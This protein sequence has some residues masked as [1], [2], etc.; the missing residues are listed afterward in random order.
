VQ[1][2]CTALSNTSNNVQQDW[3][4]SW[5]GH[6]LYCTRCCIARC[7]V[8]QQVGALLVLLSAPSSCCITFCCVLQ[9][10]DKLIDPS[11]VS[12]CYRITKQIGMLATGLPGER[13]MRAWPAG[14]LGRS[15]RSEWAA[16]VLRC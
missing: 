8:E 13:R 14:W 10:Q 7:S 11:S 5:L 9:V 4:D 3:R 15:L 16:R 2:A 1:A 12:R 6:A